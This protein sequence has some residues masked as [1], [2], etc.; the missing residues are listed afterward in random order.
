MAGGG[1]SI[2]PNDIGLFD[3]TNDQKPAGALRLGRPHPRSLTGSD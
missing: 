1:R 3:N 2:G